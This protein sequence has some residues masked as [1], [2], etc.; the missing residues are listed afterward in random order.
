MCRLVSIRDLSSWERKSDLRNRFVSANCFHSLSEMEFSGN[1]HLQKNIVLS[2]KTGFSWFTVFCFAGC[3]KCVKW[4]C[5]PWW[6]SSEERQHGY[7]FSICNG[8]HGIYLGLWRLWIQAFQMAQ[9]WCCPTR[10]SIQIHCFPGQFSNC[11]IVVK[12]SWFL[13]ALALMSRQTDAPKNC[14]LKE[15]GHRNFRAIFSVIVFMGHRK[16]WGM[17]FKAIVVRFT[18]SLF[19]RNA[20][21]SVTMDVWS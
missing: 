10:I 7:V 15:L 20:S 8:S 3:K 16:C 18:W 13:E 1:L 19:K 9:R 2:W 14:F 17:L 11:G 6:N 5:V 4:W 21:C 12:S